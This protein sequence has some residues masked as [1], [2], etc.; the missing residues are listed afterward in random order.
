VAGAAF[1]AVDQKPDPNHLAVTER[2]CEAEER[3]RHHA[4][5]HQVVA[6]RNVETE[7]PTS[8]EEH[9]QDENREQKHARRVTRK[10]IK[11][12]EKNAYHS[13]PRA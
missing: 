6:G 1:E 12:V 11:P 2:V 13:N 7:R 3:R 10:L 5:R 9:H 8:R 4:P